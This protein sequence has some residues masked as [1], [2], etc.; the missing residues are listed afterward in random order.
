MP[1]INAHVLLLGTFAGLV[2]VGIAGHM[3]KLIDDEH[4]GVVV[5]LYN[6]KFR[7]NKSQH[8]N[9]GAIEQISW[10]LLNNHCQVM[11]RGS[12]LGGSPYLIQL[13]AIETQAPGENPNPR[14]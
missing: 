9:W 10:R 11:N 1:P 8:R 4:F 13:V 14:N 6:S 12:H 7:Q 5:H 2:R 3:I